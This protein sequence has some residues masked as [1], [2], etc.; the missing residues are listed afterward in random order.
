MKRLHCI[1]AWSFAAYLAGSL[2][3]CS[4]QHYQIGGLLEDAQDCVDIFKDIIVANETT[5]ACGTDLDIDGYAELAGPRRPFVRL[6]ISCT[7]PLIW[8]CKST[9]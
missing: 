7:Q 2:V 5:R 8:R 3:G 1:Y 4:L 9:L 6:K